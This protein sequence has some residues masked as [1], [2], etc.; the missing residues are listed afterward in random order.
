MITAL[1]TNAIQPPTIKTVTINAKKYFMLYSYF[2]FFRLADPSHS[3]SEFKLFDLCKDYF[4]IFD[5]PTYRNFDFCPN[6]AWFYLSG[7]I[8]HFVFLIPNVTDPSLNLPERQKCLPVEIE[9]RGD[10]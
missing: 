1:T 5:Y 10:N 6:F 4:F 8:N 7:G 2:N 3:L 9:R